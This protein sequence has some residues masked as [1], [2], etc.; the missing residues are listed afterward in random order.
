M[1]LT[2]GEKMS[3]GA[4]TQMPQG[5]RFYLL[6]A[7]VTCL[8]AGGCIPTEKYETTVNLSAP[9]P[10]EGTFEAKTHNGYINI[11]GADVTQCSL[12]ATITA[13]ANTKENAQK[14]AE[15]V[16]VTL[17]PSGNRLIA[18][19]KKPKLIPGR[20]ISVSLDVNVPKQTGAEL[21]THNGAMKII[22]LKGNISGTTHNGQITAKKISGT[23][24]LKTHNGKITGKEITGN[25]QFHTHNGSIICEEISGDIKLSTHNGSVK[26]SYSTS[27]TP[28]CNI[29]MVTHNGG[30]SLAAPPKFSAKANVSTHNGSINTDLPI[31]ITGKVNKRKITG[32]IGAGQG[33]LHL[34]TH[35]GS[36]NIK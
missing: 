5:F 30:I 2:K 24:K 26:A 21:I 18:K 23:S 20:Y 17:V 19:I 14:L 36:I 3:K 15:E 22:N 25:A 6:V 35:N 31:T 12:T 1:L 32:T 27:A 7:A 9:L 13:R 28:V 10:A 33:N 8:Y 34:E 11:T 4:F 29:S 16:K